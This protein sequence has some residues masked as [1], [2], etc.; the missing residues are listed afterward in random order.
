MTYQKLQQGLIDDVRKMFIVAL[1][2]GVLS[3]CLPQFF[4]LPLLAVVLPLLCMI[5]Y[6]WVGYLHSEDS[7]FMEQFADSVYYLGFLLTLVA[8]VI[9]LYF[10]QSDTLEAGVLTANFS[11]ALITTIFGLAVRIFINNFQIDLNGIERQMMT[12]VEHAANDMIRKSKLISM[13]LEVSH[14]ETQV[15]IRK[16]VDDA[17]AEIQKTVRSID[18]YAT[19]NSEALVK[20]T[21]KTNLMMEQAV[22]NFAESIKNTKILENVFTEKLDIPLKQ[23]VA[24]LDDTQQMQKTLNTGQGEIAQRTQKMVAS[25]GKSVAEVDILTQ[26]ITVF[27][28]KLY[29]NT[30]V[31]KEFARVVADI[32]SLAEKTGHISQ[33]LT[34]QTE[35]S[36]LAMQNFSKMVAAVDDL[37]KDIQALSGSIKQSSE[38]ISTTFQALANKADTGTRIAK[39]LQDISTALG[40]SRETVKQISDFGLHV[41]ST[42][43]RLENFNS[44]MEQHTRIMAD[45]GGVA[46]L[47]IDLAKQ[48]QQE[49]SVIL[50]QSRQLMTELLND[51]IKR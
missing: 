33:N 27:N 21:R 17:T 51:S 19:A 48:H 6:T 43:K 32:S 40:S 23:L 3:V 38:H 47:D 31:N 29:A 10:Y 9:S 24:R 5:I 7:S 13:Q 42:F 11:L 12:E 1:V 37:P 25:M 14:Q 2:G 22:T 26:S 36:T 39:D 46:K 15:A 20:S 4:D 35:Q 18:Q 30:K 50:K 45:M 8:L 34:Q 44:M 28:D 49:M 16:S 41:T